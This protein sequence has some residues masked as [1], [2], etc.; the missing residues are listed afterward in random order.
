[1][2]CFYI[3]IYI[4]TCNYIKVLCFLSLFWGDKKPTKKTGF[5]MFL[6]LIKQQAVYQSTRPYNLAMLKRTFKKNYPFFEKSLDCKFLVMDGSLTTNPSIS[7]LILTWHP[8][9]DL[10]D[11][12][13]RISYI[14]LKILPTFK[15]LPGGENVRLREPKSQI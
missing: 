9:R 7:L 11:T 1:M 4:Q 12:P 13:F 3:R 5:R 2:H 10:S 15:I 6:L 8:N 14:P